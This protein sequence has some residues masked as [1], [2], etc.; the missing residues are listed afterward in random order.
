M[1]WSSA[2]TFSAGYP[3]N[4]GILKA[5]CV[6]DPPSFLSTLLSPKKAQSRE[7]TWPTRLVDDGSLLLGSPTSIIGSRYLLHHL[8][9][10]LQPHVR[11][12]P[13]V[14]PPPP[15]PPRPIRQRPLPTTNT[16]DTSSDIPLPQHLQIGI[17]FSVLY[18]LSPSPDDTTPISP[19]SPARRRSR[20]SFLPV[21]RYD[22]SPPSPSPP[23]RC[24]RLLPLCTRPQFPAPGVIA[25]TCLN[26]SRSSEVHT[27][28]APRT[29]ISVISA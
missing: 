4:H 27:T 29:S 17:S 19:L 8:P 12:P 1:P 23:W 18:A 16:H 7:L 26:P 13:V 15:P 11:S 6:T 28:L 9:S 20:R 21:A 14:A 2:L 24:L 10:R 5:S 22:D 25:V 3:S